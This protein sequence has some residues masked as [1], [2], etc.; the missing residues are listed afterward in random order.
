MKGKKVTQE[1]F[2]IHFAHI[3]REA[4]R[5]MS[6]DGATEE[7]CFEAYAEAIEDSYQNIR[8]AATIRGCRPSQKIQRSL[9]LTEIREVVIVRK[10]VFK[11]SYV[12]ESYED[13]N[14]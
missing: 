2:S 1:D 8:D 10:S 5:Q 14:S 6:T 11:Y 13:D 9:G 4:T 7:E 12:D 3:V